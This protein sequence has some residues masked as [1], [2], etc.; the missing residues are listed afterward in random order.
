[1][2]RGATET[3]NRMFGLGINIHIHRAR[4]DS[5]VRDILSTT[6]QTQ[7]YFG[8]SGELIIGE[9]GIHM[10]DDSPDDLSELYSQIRQDTADFTKG[11][12][13]GSGWG[14]GA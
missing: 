9:W 12:R 8:D 13:R 1:M 11:D 7:A 5:E 14:R 3:L 6:S 2:T 4:T 10:L